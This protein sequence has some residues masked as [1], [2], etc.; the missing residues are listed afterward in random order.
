MKT[1]LW[2]WLGGRSRGGTEERV[3]YMKRVTWN[4]LP[5]AKQIVNEN[6]LYDSGYSIQ[7]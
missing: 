1:D 4:T 2:T 3:E 6:F 7:G 5:Y